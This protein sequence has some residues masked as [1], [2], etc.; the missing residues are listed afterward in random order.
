MGLNFEDFRQTVIEDSSLQHRLRG[1]TNTDDFVTRCVN[2]GH[3]LGHEFT[4]SDV[5]DALDTARRVWL[6][7]WL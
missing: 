4:A 7:R 6:Q 5:R 1:M 3:E 2:L